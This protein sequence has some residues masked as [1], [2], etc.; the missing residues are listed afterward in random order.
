MRAHYI[1][2]A[3]LNETFSIL[4]SG[5]ARDSIAYVSSRTCEADTG[6]SC[7]SGKWLLGPFKVRALTANDINA[8]E[9]GTKC[10]CQP[11]V[12]DINPAYNR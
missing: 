7:R 5:V 11:T 4:V 12:E 10:Y 6:P 1:K 2:N 3:N 9:T 8:A